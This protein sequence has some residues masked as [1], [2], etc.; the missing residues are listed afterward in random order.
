LKN[1]SILAIRF[2]WS[3]RVLAKS[4]PH[5]KQLKELAEI[6]AEE[7]RQSGPINFARF[8]EL[9]LYC[10]VYGYYER[11][12]DTIGRGGDFITSVSVGGIFGELLAFQFSEWLEEVRRGNRTDETAAGGAGAGSEAPGGKVQLV[13]SG[14]HDG[15]LAVD[16]LGWLQ[17]HRTCLFERLEYWILE[18]SAR[19]REI[20]Q[21]RLSQFGPMVKWT[22]G[23]EKLRRD[24]L[25]TNPRKERRNRASSTQPSP[26]EEERGTTSIP[27]GS[28]DSAREASL[29]RILLRRALPSTSPE[30]PWICGVIFSNE[31]L[32]ALPARRLGWDAAKRRWFE[33]GV[34]YDGGRF[35]WAR[36]P[37]G[38]E[39][40]GDDHIAALLPALPNGFTIEV[41]PAAAEWWRAAAS[42]LRRGKLLTLDYGLTAEER[43]L[44]E[45]RQGTVRAFYRHHPSDDIL[46]RPGEQD[47][48][49]HVDFTELIRAG[50]SAGLATEQ[51][52]T[53]EKFLMEI[54]RRVWSDGSLADNWTPQR[55][56]QFRT[57][58]HPDHLGRAFR[59]LV[60][61]RT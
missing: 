14:A 46:A 52:V 56:R 48:T 32:D 1:A 50:E 28:L 45:R 41:C 36:L 5:C 34:G 12:E 29:R 44:P 42:L 13:E 30:E 15:R 53:Q 22:S 25:R 23:F 60:Q 4:A 61:S 55:R 8:M 33:W 19:R 2:V 47:L 11:H 7:I 40:P 58:T 43:I 26:P 54:A 16:I 21:N 17:R 3:C 59:L 24:S 9:A 37:Y 18:P 57:L 10:P 31:L 35:R 27:A 51:F 20:Q 39:E 49:A 6:I 38:E